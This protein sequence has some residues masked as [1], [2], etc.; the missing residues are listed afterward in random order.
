[1]SDLSRD[2][3]KSKAA[4]LSADHDVALKTIEKIS[5]RLADATPDACDREQT[6]R[7]ISELLD[8]AEASLRG[9]KK[10]VEDVRVA[11]QSV[12]ILQTYDGLGKRRVSTNTLD[13]AKRY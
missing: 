13:A 2:L 6:R 5:A 4:I 10:G 12:R 8:L 11:V 7:Q 9:A 3:A 1:M